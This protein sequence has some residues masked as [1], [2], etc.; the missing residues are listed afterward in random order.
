MLRIFGPFLHQPGN[1]GLSCVGTDTPCA[2]SRLFLLQMA[3]H[4]QEA[5]LLGDY[6]TTASREFAF[7]LTALLIMASAVVHCSA[8]L[9]ASYSY[10]GNPSAVSTSFTESQMGQLDLQPS[11]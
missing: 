6:T 10:V 7:F 2:F 11:C 1:I 3:Q 5:R 8:L 9:P 4:D